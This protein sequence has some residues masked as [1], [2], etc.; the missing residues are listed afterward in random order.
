VGKNNQQR[1]LAFP[2]VESIE[3]ISAMT[4][5]DDKTGDVTEN[6][7][8]KVREPV[9][10]AAVKKKRA[11]S[12]STKNAKKKKPAPKRKPTSK[13]SVRRPFPQNTLEEAIKVA[14][15]IRDKN[16]GKAFDTEDVAKVFELSKKGMP[17]FYL[18]GSSR[19]YGLTDGSRDTKQI[20]LTDLGSNIVYPQTAEQEKQSKIEAFLNVPL[21]QKVYDHYGGGTLPEKQ[22]VSSVLVKKFD[23]DESLHDDFCTLYQ[24]NCKFLSLDDEQSGLQEVSRE[25]EANGEAIVLRQRGT[26]QNQAFI[27]MPFSEKGDNPRPD[28]FFSE[29]LKSLIKPACNAADFGV[30]TARSLG[31]DLIHHTIIRQLD[32]APLVIADLTDHNPNVLFELGVRIALDK[33]VLLIRAKGTPPIFDVDNM[34]RVCEYDPRLWKTTIEA[35]ITTLT[36]HIRGGW[37]NREKNPSYMR[38]LKTGQVGLAGR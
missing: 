20:S 1:L 25:G 14:Q 19:D 13:S 6:S 12:N 9:K 30:E 8:S 31:S 10:K 36:D 37:E 27:V 11:K 17:F 34:M 2:N 38:I 7:G 22:Y 29:V 18:A 24:A 4:D 15:A 23:L 28:S 33:P 3:G 21:F 26:Y 16:N 32:E 5:S 35:D